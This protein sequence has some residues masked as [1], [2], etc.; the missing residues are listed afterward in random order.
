MAGSRYSLTPKAFWQYL[1][2][3]YRGLDA[4]LSALESG[5]ADKTAL[6][7]VA[8]TGKAAD[9]IGGG[10]GGSA[11]AAGVTASS[12]REE[13][14]PY[15]PKP[16]PATQVSASMTVWPDTSA[17]WATSLVALGENSRLGFVA[18]VPTNATEPLK[19]AEGTSQGDSYN[20]SA[21]RTDVPAGSEVVLSA[22][23][24]FLTAHFTTA[25]QPVRIKQITGV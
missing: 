6:A 21:P 23:N 3:A 2:P 17:Q 5:K 1:G 18:Q 4:D 9:L 22:G 8:F 15:L 24:T 20:P 25:S 19:V 12:A 11:S 10:G 16:Y 14:Y 7:T 13:V